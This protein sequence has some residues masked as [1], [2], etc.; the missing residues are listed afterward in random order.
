M[1]FV[2]LVIFFF[3]LLLLFFIWIHTFPLKRGGADGLIIL[4]YRCKG[5]KIH[6][7]LEERLLVAINLLQS[8]HFEK[9]IVTGGNVGS[10]ISEAEIMKT[11]LVENGIGE[12]RIIIENKAKDTIENLFYCGDIMKAYRIKTC[13]I[14]SNSFHLR[15]VRYIAKSIG[16]NTDFYCSRNL[17]TILKQALRTINEL[18]IFIKTFRTLKEWRIL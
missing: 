4:G 15:R 18:R 12:D 9:V 17:K 14:V 8:F 13:M 3:L 1:N 7:F 11:Y 10:T 5:N 2:Y 16:F 6:P